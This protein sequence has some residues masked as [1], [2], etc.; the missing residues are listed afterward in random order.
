MYEARLWLLGGRRA[1]QTA[2]HP[3]NVRRP[4]K[5]ASKNFP[6]TYKTIRRIAG[7]RVSEASACTPVASTGTQSVPTRVPRQT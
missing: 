4:F 7:D 2:T 6:S 5:E 3:G 1:Y